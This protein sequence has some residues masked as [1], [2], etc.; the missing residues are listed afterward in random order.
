MSQTVDYTTGEADVYE[1]EN[2][3]S[4]PKENIKRSILKTFSWRALG[5]IT[6]VVVSYIIT[7]TLALAFSIGGAGSVIKAFCSSVSIR[8]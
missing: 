1:V 2:A 6:T 5:T 8:R 7:G 4:L 3:S